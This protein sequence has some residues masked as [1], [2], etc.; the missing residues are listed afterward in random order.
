MRE[1]TLQDYKSRILRVL[2]HI[3]RHLDDELD[4]DRLAGVAAFSPYHFHRVFRGMVGESVKSHVRR[5]RLERAATRLKLSRH[6][7]TTIA[8]DSGYRSHEAFTRAFRE[9]FG[10]SPSEFRS[11]R[12]VA[13][14]APVPSGVHYGGSD[15]PVDFRPCEHEGQTMQVTIEE[16]EPIRVAFMRHV[17]P[18][19]QCGQTWDRFLTWA[20]AEGLVGGAPRF[21]GLCHDDPEITPGTKIR[22]DACLTVDASFKPVDEIGVQVIEGGPYARAT[23]FGPYHRLG[24]TYAKFLGQWAPRSGRGIRAA[25]CFEVYLNSPES[26]DPEDLLTDIYLALE[27]DR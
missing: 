25:P 27:P 18:Y 21:I 17:G 10:D 12:T 11:T 5:L 3:Q 15:G 1:A 9:L 2:V 8:L 14:R 13:P 24:E 22:Y 7:V 26:T 19:D 20:G 4:L 23:H 16:V 6:P